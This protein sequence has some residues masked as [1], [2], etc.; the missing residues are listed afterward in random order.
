[1]SKKETSLYQLQHFLPAD[2]FHMVAPYFKD[3]TIHLTLTRDRKTVLGDYREPTKDDP[4]H[5]VTVNVNLN[6]YNFLITLVHELAHMVTHNQ[7]GR[8]AAA[9]GKEWKTQFRH[10]LMPFV[11]KDIF[12]KDVE[13]ALI[14]YMQNPAAST[15]T[16]HNLYRALY[17]YDR[18]KK[19][20]YML[21]TDL[22]VGHW[23]QIDDGRVFEKLEQLRTRSL[24]KEVGTRKKYYFPG[25]YEVKRVRR[26]LKRTA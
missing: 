4:Y 6:P 22:A 8:K 18:N 1:M 24:C 19:E 20:G 12:P 9:H 26:E 15:C 13:A 25:I 5:R 2:T 23:F 21:M 10:M 16:D 7:F 14:K 11:G 3:Y 17:K